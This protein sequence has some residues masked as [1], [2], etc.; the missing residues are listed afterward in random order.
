MYAASRP[1]RIRFMSATT[2]L[3][4][5]PC[6]VHCAPLLA[7]FYGSFGVAEAVL[8]EE[9]GHEAGVVVGGMA[10]AASAVVGMASLADAVSAQMAR[11]REESQRQFPPLPRPAYEARVVAL[12][13][14]VEDYLGNSNTLL[15]LGT[16]CVLRTVLAVLSVFLFIF[17]TVRVTSPDRQVETFPEMCPPTHAESCV[18]VALFVPQ[19]N[20]GLKP[21][22]VPNAT[23]A[24]VT[25]ALLDWTNTRHGGKILRYVDNTRFRIGSLVLTHSRFITR[26]WGFASDFFVSLSCEG[27]D[28]G[29][30]V[31]AQSMLRLGRA[32]AG[33]QLSHVR[34]LF[35]HLEQHADRHPGMLCETPR[36]PMLGGF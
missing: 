29:V 27:A 11:A 19:R 16:A 18:R 3:P 20:D 7:L 12:R 35:A 30:L 10:I 6:P 17:L 31:E 1:F 21:L 36:V 15:K 34:S 5:I 4:R 9:W 23:L 26:F 32:G 33:A 14:R 13:Q 25:N 2:T 8:A 24:S 22:E 28:G